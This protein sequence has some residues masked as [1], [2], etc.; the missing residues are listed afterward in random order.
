MA[1][2]NGWIYGIRRVLRLLSF[3]KNP[4]IEIENAKQHW[5]RFTSK[6][7]SVLFICQ[8]K[9][10]NEERHIMKSSFKYR[11]LRKEINELLFSIGVL[12]F[13]IFMFI[14]TYYVTGALSVTRQH[15]FFNSATIPRGFAFLGVLMAL[16]LICQ[17][18]SGLLRKS[19]EM[20]ANGRTELDER[21][22]AELKE[23]RAGFLRVLLSIVNL[24][25]FVAL[26]P[27]LGVIV[28]GWIY[29]GTQIYIMLP[30]EVHGF[31]TYTKAAV[32]AFVTPVTIYFSFRFLFN[33]LF[34]IGILK[35]FWI[36]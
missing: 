15:V 7:I 13:F 31:K 32:I 6:S 21:E 3:N 30:R 33:I 9:E 35:G 25:V 10:E 16:M 11:Y 26:I 19:R 12:A 23:E 14:Q 18:S 20:P 1:E 29:I 24:S 27:M 36:F 22:A 34:P 28:G 17:S 5:N 4:L 2:A 8:Q